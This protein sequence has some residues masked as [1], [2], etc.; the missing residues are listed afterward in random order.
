MW[1]FGET[2]TQVPTPELGETQLAR[3]QP[4]ARRHPTKPV[5]YAPLAIVGDAAGAALPVY[6]AFAL[7][8]GTN[9]M[10]YT[11]VITASWLLVRAARVRYAGRQ[12]GEGGSASAA[13]GDW[14]VLVGLLAVMRAATGEQSPFLIA[15][16]G[17]LPCAPL[18]AAGHALISRHLLARRRDGRSVR[19]ALVIGEP[20]AVDGL[21]GHLAKRTDH[22][23]IV[24][25]LCPI[26]EEDPRSLA[27]VAAR[28]GKQTPQRLSADSAPVREAAR[29]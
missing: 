2:M 6:L 18:S 21:V 15:L 26:G 13:R 29:Q 7:A 4:R 8:G 28:L 20:A 27:P 10:W 23:F 16:S 19:R 14:L 5:W 22:E 9:A 25:G 24:V 3:E 17:L 12:L 11:A 1:V